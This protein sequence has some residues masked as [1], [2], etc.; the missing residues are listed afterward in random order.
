[1]KITELMIGDYVKYQ[2]HTYIVEEISAKG[3]VHL[4]HPESKVRLNLTN[5]YIIHLLEPIPLTQFILET[6]GWIVKKNHVQKGNFG[7]SPLMLWHLTGNKILR[8]FV[9]EME[10]SDLSSDEGYRLRFRCDY[11]HELQ[12]ALRLCGL[13]ELADNFKMEE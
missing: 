8:H 4:I 10:I 2:G 3:W 6:N 12:H 5:D 13:N 11:V 1:M 9:H 7:D